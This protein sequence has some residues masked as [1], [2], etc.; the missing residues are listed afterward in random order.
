[1][2]G[3]VLAVLLAMTAQPVSADPGATPPGCWSP[4]DAPGLFAWTASPGVACR[5]AAETAAPDPPPVPVAVP[6]DLWPPAPSD[7]VPATTVTL[8][9][10]AYF[11]VA[12]AF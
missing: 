3:G 1:M 5:D 6:L 12:A 4:G 7:A 8:S 11:G 9:G 10:T 2:R